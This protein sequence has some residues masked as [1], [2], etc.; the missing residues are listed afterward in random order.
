MSVIQ[1]LHQGNWQN[2]EVLGV[3]VNGVLEAVEVVGQAAEFTT[4]GATFAPRVYLASGSTA[5]VQWIEGTTVLSTSLT[6]TLTW[7]SAGARTIK[8]VC[9]NP[10]DVEV[11]NFGYDHTEDSGTYMPAA[12]YDYAPQ[13]LT[14]VS[15]LQYFS[16]L[17]MFLAS[18]TPTTGKL[19]LFGM[20]HLE[21]AECYDAGF[22][23][24][25][26]TGCDSLIRLNLEMNALTY[27]DLNPVRSTLRDLRFAAQAGGV[28]TFASLDGPMTQLYHY[29]VRSQAVTNIVPLS[30]LP[31]VRQYWVWNTGITTF[32]TP[33]STI[34]NSLRAYG[35][36]L[37]QTTIDSTLAWI[38]QNVPGQYGSL[39]L[40]L[41]TSST[42]S[43]TG[44]AAYDELTSRTGWA[45]QV[46]GVHP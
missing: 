28:M 32:A 45:V 44:W 26:L 11:L 15:N 14:G 20:S 23:S 46:N 17:K 36:A 33:V 2:A 19:D 12:S 9:S 31:A 1:V 43:A 5:T 3:G 38:S 34:L 42:P 22:T 40:D 39:R 29:C 24:T 16:Q 37:D 13:P 4:N 21:F 18:H 41:G 27:L 30:L 35:N 7:G 25:D 8:L 10:S 6:P